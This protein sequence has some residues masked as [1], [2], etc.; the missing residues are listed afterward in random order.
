[1]TSLAAA[2]PE[3]CCWPVTRITDSEG[4][5]ALMDD[6]VGVVDPASFLFNPKRLDASAGEAVG[7]SLLAVR[8]AGPGAAFGEEAAVGEPRFEEKAG[9]VADKGGDAAGFEEAGDEPLDPGIAAECE[10]G[11]LASG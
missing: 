1:M 7:E 2:A 10:H 3:N 11:R 8:K 5:E 4:T 9:G 6:E